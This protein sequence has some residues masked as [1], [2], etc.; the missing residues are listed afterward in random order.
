MSASLPNQNMP[1]NLNVSGQLSCATFA[2]PDE[3]ID[4]D[5]VETGANIDASKLE[6][7]HSLNYAQDP[8]GAVAAATQDIIY[9]TA[10][11][12]GVINSINAFITG[13]LPTGDGT[14]TV[15]LKKSTEFGA[16]ASVLTGVIT[17]DSGNVLRVPEAGLFSSNTLQFGDILQ[18]VIAQ[19]KSTGNQAKG[20]LVNLSID[21]QGL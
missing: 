18:L 11:N 14:V 1:V 9:I 21:E 5:A 10:T 2:P 8:S 16:F 7:R 3:C 6:H 20:L 15:D 4:D 19:G 13:T 17:L 12:G